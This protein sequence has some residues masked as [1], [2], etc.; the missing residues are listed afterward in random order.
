M[1][2]IYR[3]Y[4]ELYRE[5][6]RKRN[7]DIYYELTGTGIM[8]CAVCGAAAELLIFLIFGIQIGAVPVPVIGF[9]WLLSSILA[10]GVMIGFESLLDLRRR[11]VHTYARHRDAKSKC[12]CTHSGQYAA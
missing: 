1:R 6:S 2:R 7:T 12:S 11:A 3:L 8:V 5:S 9:L 4:R 10:S